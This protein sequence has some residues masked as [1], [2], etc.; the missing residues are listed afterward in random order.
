MTTKI[1][2]LNRQSGAKL[3]ELGA[4]TNSTKI[5]ASDLKTSATQK[6]VDEL[7]AGKVLDK[8]MIQPSNL[9]KLRQ[10]ANRFA[11][12][13]QIYIRYDL[14]K[15]GG[16]KEFDVRIPEQIA[17]EIYLN[18]KE[19]IGVLKSE[20]KLKAV[21]G[22]EVIANFSG[23]IQKISE[24][25]RD[26]N[27]NDPKLIVLHQAPIIEKM[28][29]DTLAVLHQIKQYKHGPNKNEAKKFLK[30]FDQMS[31][32][33]LKNLNGRLPTRPGQVGT[34]SKPTYQATL[35]L[36]ELANTVRKS[37]G[38]KTYPKMFMKHD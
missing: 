1:L 19:W 5:E 20:G 22:G 15:K 31:G 26:Q 18:P 23:Y 34:F 28:K 38:E 25:S 30:E 35:V 32:I 29:Q 3:N 10:T 36:F 6:I 7:V 4:Q 21:S 27:I 17:Q 9:E 11:G 33:Y 12:M 14:D 37:L 8:K 16:F 13:D 2:I 24:F